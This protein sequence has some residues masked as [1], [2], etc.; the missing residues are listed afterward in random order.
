LGRTAQPSEIDFWQDEVERLVSAGVSAPEALR[1]VAYAFITSPEFTH[2]S[3]HDAEFVTAMY[4]VLLG[5]DPDPAGLAYWMSQVSPLVNAFL[6]SPEFDASAARAAPA[7]G[8]SRPE[9]AMV[10]DFY[11]GLL[12]RLP[13]DVGLAFWVGRLRAAQCDGTV[14]AQADAISYSFVHSAEYAVVMQSRPDYVSNYTRY[15]VSGLYNA[16]LRRGSDKPGYDYWVGG[17]LSFFLGQNEFVRQQFVASPEFQ[18]RIAAVQ[19][20]GCLP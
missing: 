1:A 17:L 15:Y 18:S 10:V 8:A 4:R 7:A 2:R 9:V 5:R 19:A 6:F 11:R 20:A 13:D 14:G 16:F 3:L 12:D